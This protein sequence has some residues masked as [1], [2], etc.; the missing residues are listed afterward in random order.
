MK[1]EDA[2]ST[3]DGTRIPP[4]PL[5]DHGGRKRG[6]TVRPMGL[7]W[8]NGL[9]THAVHLTVD[10][11]N[12]DVLTFGGLVLL[13][14][15][16]LAFLEAV[17]DVVGR[18]PE[19]DAAW[20]V[21]DRD[22]TLLECELSYVRWNLGAAL[23]GA[24]V[25]MLYPEGGRGH[26]AEGIEGPGGRMTLTGFMR[27]RGMSTDGTLRRRT[28]DLSRE[29]TRTAT[30]LAELKAQLEGLRSVHVD[31]GNGTVGGPG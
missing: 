28:A 25:V 21:T 9:N 16:T 23:A 30:R 24:R 1:A 7:T 4:G 12:G 5:G 15:G 26:A 19:L 11:D 27:R 6:G 10:G 13:P 29:I 3:A 17:A 22:P 2:L 14:T 31:W 20:A 8:D 18:R